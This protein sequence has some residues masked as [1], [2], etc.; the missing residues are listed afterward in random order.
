MVIRGALK[1][2]LSVL[3]AS[4]LINMR[5]ERTR[6]I[7][8]S[9]GLHECVYQVHRLVPQQYGVTDVHPLI[10]RRKLLFKTDARQVHSNWRK[11]LDAFH[12]MR[13][14]KG[15]GLVLTGFLASYN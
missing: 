1:S 3:L 10:L 4:V 11:Q 12:T 5:L 8:N 15:C 14:R 13:V 9:L 2:S 7:V 6:G